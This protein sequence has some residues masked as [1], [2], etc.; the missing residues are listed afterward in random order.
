MSSS[1]SSNL[2]NKKI[3]TGNDPLGQAVKKDK[4]E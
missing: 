2:S 4:E 3:K 1:N